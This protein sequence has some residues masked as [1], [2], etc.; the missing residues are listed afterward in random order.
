MQIYLAGNTIFPTYI[1]PS[2]IGGGFS[3]VENASISSGSHHGRE[4]AKTRYDSD[5]VRGGIPDKDIKDENIHCRRSSVWGGQADYYRNAIKKHRPY[6]LESFYYADE[7]TEKLLPYYGDF[8][9]DSGAFT[10]MGGASFTK[11]EKKSLIWEDYIERY[12]DF[13]NRNRIEKFFELDIDSV[14]GYTKVLQYRKKLEQLTGRQVIP[15]WHSTR[16]IDEFKKMC[17]EYPYVALG[18]IVGGEWKAD[19]EKYIP[20]FIETAH[21]SRTKI[22]GLGYTKLSRLKDFHFDSV[23]STAWTTGNRF[24]FIYRF[25]GKTM[26]KIQ[27]P[28]GK[29]LADSK[30]VAEINYCEWIKFQQ[31]AV[32]AL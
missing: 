11:N 22:H 10:F 17:Q 32:K 7:T 19:K 13:I 8:L 15:V 16:G 14:V 29:R 5:I 25:N 18:G 30:K 26:E 27:C 24:G 2:L 23:D 31:Y 12:A 9:L 20:W 1:A 3:E 21:K 28:K 6:I 4:L